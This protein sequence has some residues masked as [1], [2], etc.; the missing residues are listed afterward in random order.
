MDRSLFLPY[1]FG[2]IYKFVYSQ[3]EGMLIDN[4]FEIDPQLTLTFEP[5][6]EEYTFP[7]LQFTIINE[8]QSRS[9]VI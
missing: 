1:L 2:N 5:E 6:N 9:L 3:I 4:F 8:F 7:A